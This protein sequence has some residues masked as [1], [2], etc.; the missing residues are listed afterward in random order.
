MRIEVLNTGTELLLGSV[1]NTHLQFL[2]Q[3]L[4]P[5]GLRIQRQVTV[6]DGEAIRE[7]VTETFG[8]TDVVLITGG[9][10]PTTDDITSL[11]KPS[12]NCWGW[13]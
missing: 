1:L 6:P 4:F 13:N 11:V 2:A 5:L 7:A 8:R 9:L 12:R 10:G 3:A